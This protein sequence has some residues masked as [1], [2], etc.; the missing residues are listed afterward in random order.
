[1]SEKQGD[2]YD[3]YYKTV[4]K[5]KWHY[6][7]S[8][9]YPVW[10]KIIKKLKERKIKGVLDIGCGPGQFGEMAVNNNIKYRGFDISRGAVKL[11]KE[12]KLCVWEG[13][14]FNPNNL[15]RRP[16]EAVVCTEVLEHIDGDL[17]LLGMIPSGIIFISVP[18]FGHESHV[19]RFKTWT[20]VQIRYRDYINIE[21]INKI[22]KRFL[23]IGQIE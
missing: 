13:D 5:T 15:V 11:A 16:D 23:L 21:N 9:V 8:K 19:R 14:C 1:M 12:K 7:Q 4:K 20:S 10:K 22:G 6:T 18:T 3:K 17:E 2:Y